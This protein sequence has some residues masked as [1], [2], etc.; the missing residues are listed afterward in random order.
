MKIIDIRHLKKSYGSI[1]AV[2][3]ITFDVEE[4][5]L[6]AFL[7]CNGAGKST[8]IDILCTFLKKDSGIVKIGGYDLDQE[9]QKIKEMIGIVFQQSV[10]DGM[11]TVEE[12]MKLR[13]SLYTSNKKEIQICVERVLQEM[14]L[15]HLKKRY[16][17]SLSG[18]QKRR[19]DIARALL[20]RP[21]I[22]FLDEPT[23]GLDPQTRKDVWQT[24]IHLQKKNHM[25]IFLT[26]HYMEEAMN[27]DHVVIMDEGK[28]I[29]QGTPLQLRQR[30]THD[31]LILYVNNDF[32]YERLKAS[33][34]QYHSDDTHIYI[35]LKHTFDALEIIRTYQEYINDFE[36]VKGN[37]DDAFIQITGKELHA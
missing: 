27:A 6:F 29:E 31:R 33:T 2:K 37:M 3:D 4:G 5:A 35:E 26:T 14:G 7:G 34:L 30:Y 15:E 25:T 24:I 21:R 20:H 23:T 13:A 1:Q 22:L 16:Y 32:P 9:S 11:L 28:I 36:V 18:G 12:N 10:L 17:S 19:C 8:T